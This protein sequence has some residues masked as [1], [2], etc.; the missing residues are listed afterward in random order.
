MRFFFF[1]TLMDPDVREVVVGRPVPASRIE[2]ATLE[3]FRRMCVAGR[4]CPMLIPDPPGRVEGCLVRGLDGRA[5]ARIGRFEGDEYRPERHW[6]RLSGGVRIEAYVYMARSG[7]RAGRTPWELST[8]QRRHKRAL[9]E[10]ARLWLGPGAPGAR[11]CPRE[12]KS[13]RR[14]RRRG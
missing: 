1:G 10:R 12:G 7:V 9:L 5:R 11:P 14:T 3:G 8:W 2:P 13:D 4:S 6:V